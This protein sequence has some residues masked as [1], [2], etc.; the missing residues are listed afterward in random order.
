[1]R[2]FCIFALVAAL[3]AGSVHAQQVTTQTTDAPVLCNQWAAKKITPPELISGDR[4]DYPIEAELEHIDGICSVSMVVSILGDPQNI[5]IL[6]C[7]DSSF[8]ETSL[9]A[10][11]Q[12]KFKPATTPEG[13]PVPVV[14][15]T[16]LEYHLVKNVVSLRS[17]GV[18]I[19]FRNHSDRY[20][21]DIH[22]SMKLPAFFD[23][24]LIIDRHS[25]K[26]V[27]KREIKSQINYGF[28]PLR[29]GASVP[30][31]DGVYPFTRR[32]T[33]PR[34]IKFFDEGYGRAA[35]AHEGNEA[36]DVML[37]IDTKGRASD[38][39]VTHCERPELEEP[40]VQSLL[41][42][43]Y[44]PGYVHGKEV[45]MRASMRLEYSDSPT[46]PE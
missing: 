35:F 2:R 7:T 12:Y 46:P 28:I 6:H 42:S 13:K 25:S 34:V 24:G 1:M 29:G 39:Q 36:C 17:V 19:F 9:D 11:K 4:A 26:S 40:A 8:E 15:Q 32:V 5:R 22:M 38:P 21:L 27:V 16:E 33:G 43:R 23:K 14:V 10:V 41:K 45:P 30:D 37:T 44:Q 3:V 20:F 31:S 18:P